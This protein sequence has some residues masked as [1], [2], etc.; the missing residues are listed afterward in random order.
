VDRLANHEHVLLEVG[1]PRLNLAALMMM[2]A[3]NRLSSELTEPLDRAMD[4]RISFQGQMRSEL[5]VIASEGRK[6]LAQVG[7]AEDDDVIKAFPT[8]RADQS[9]RVPVLPG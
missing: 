1:L 8:D 7:F 5:V 3:K 4:R 6:N 2:S 9:L